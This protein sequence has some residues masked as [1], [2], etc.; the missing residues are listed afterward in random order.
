MVALAASKTGAAIGLSCESRYNW[1]EQRGSNHRYSSCW[2]S[3]ASHCGVRNHEYRNKTAMLYLLGPIQSFMIN[4][5]SIQYD[6]PCNGFFK[7]LISSLLITRGPIFILSS[8]QSMNTCCGPSNFSIGF[9][10]SES[11]LKIINEVSAWHITDCR[12]SSIQWSE[13]I[14]CVNSY[15]EWNLLPACRSQWTSLSSLISGK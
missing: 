14:S 15:M 4:W 11:H 1:V 5:N 3:R 7:P 13:R 6:S 2:W 9:V 12:S 10:F 8:T